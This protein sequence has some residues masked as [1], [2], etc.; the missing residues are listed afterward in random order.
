MKHTEPLRLN[1]PLF[2]GE[3]V[4]EN[5]SVVIENGIITA[6]NEGESVGTGY[7]LMPG[8]MDA[9]THMGTVEQIEAMLANGVTATCDVAAPAS[10]V[11]QSK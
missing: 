5:A 3:K 8:L 6:V 4:L 11:Q 1:Y 2:D 9:H 10:L 7:F